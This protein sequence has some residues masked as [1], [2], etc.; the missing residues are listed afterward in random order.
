[1]ARLLGVIPEPRPAVI[2]EPQ[3][4]IPEPHCGDCQTTF[5]DTGA[6]FRDSRATER[7][8][9]PAKTAAFSRP[10]PYNHMNYNNKS[11]ML[12]PSRFAREAVN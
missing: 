3:S 2:A 4:V 10:N 5:G 8:I 1:M 12:L 9:G 7:T 11:A 6:T